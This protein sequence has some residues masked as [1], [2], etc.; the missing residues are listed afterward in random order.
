MITKEDVAKRLK[1]N[2]F[3]CLDCKVKFLPDLLQDKPGHRV[4][5]VVTSYCPP[6]DTGGDWSPIGE[7]SVM[8]TEC[9]KCGKETSYLSSEPPDKNP[10]AT[11]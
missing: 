6:R 2:C 4:R 3:Q 11:K 7:A 5:L 10:Q 9:P 1:G 8:I